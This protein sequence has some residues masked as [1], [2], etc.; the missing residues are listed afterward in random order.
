[1]LRDGFIPF[2]GQHQT[3]IDVDYDAAV[4]KQFVMYQIAN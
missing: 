3:R 4:I 1:M 2:V